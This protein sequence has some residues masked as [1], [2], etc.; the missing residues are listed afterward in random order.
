[1]VRRYAGIVDSS[2]VA[3]YRERMHKGRDEK[4]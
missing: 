3:V 1:M 2:C 4:L